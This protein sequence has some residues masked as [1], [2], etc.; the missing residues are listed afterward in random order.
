MQQLEMHPKL[1]HQQ[2]QR[3]TK[4]IAAATGLSMEAYPS[5]VRGIDLWA[6]VLVDRIGA[7]TALSLA[8]TSKS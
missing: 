8:A 4:L 6:R 3:D 7:V 5:T 2:S 1:Q